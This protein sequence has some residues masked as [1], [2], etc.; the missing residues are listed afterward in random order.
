MVFFSI[1]KP[2]ELLLLLLG[3]GVL[4][5]VELG[6]PELLTAGVGEFAK[7]GGEIVPLSGL[8]PQD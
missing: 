8:W 3:A 2:E 4:D 5:G 1:A 6:V 7:G